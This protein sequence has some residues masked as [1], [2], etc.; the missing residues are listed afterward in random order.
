VFLLNTT[1][2][3]EDG[4]PN[5]HAKTIE[6]K[7]AVTKPTLKK[8][9]DERDHLV[10]MLWGRHAQ[11]FEHILDRGRHLVLKASHPS[12][13]SV[14]HFQACGHFREANN[15]LTEHR[16]EPIAWTHLP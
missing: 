2:T 15:Y 4:C 11:S 12:P 16:I 6:W 8:L 1:L 5:S 10:F 14:K 13:R 3:V 7:E 9:S